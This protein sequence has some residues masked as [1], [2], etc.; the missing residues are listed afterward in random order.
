MSNY[1]KRRASPGNYSRAL[2]SSG[3]TRFNKKIWKP[4]LGFMLA[5]LLLG[6]LSS[7]FGKA[8]S[9]LGLA[10]DLNISDFANGKVIADKD[11]YKVG[12]TVTLIVAPADGY[13]PKLYINDSPL[14]LNWKNNT[15]SFVATEKIY[16][17][18]GSFEKSLD[19]SYDEDRWS[20]ANHAHGILDAY[21]ITEDSSWLMI[22]GEY[23]SVAV[24]AK[25]YLAGEDGSGGEGFAVSLGLK[26]TNNGNSK[27]YTF[28]VVKQGGIY[29]LQ[30]FNI[31]GDWTK[32]VLDAAAVTAI[33]GEGVDFKVV[34]TSAN[35]LT[36]FVNGVVCDTYEMAD[37][38]E[39][40][41]VSSVNIGLYGNPNAQI[42]IPYSLG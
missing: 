35:M 20:V 42:A 16:K 28:R 22:N 6:F 18:T 8:P 41:K 23:E 15:Y 12:D 34:R 3:R 25:N 17:I 14:L 7:M 9:K 38:T 13:S 33:S 2:R 32:H 19:M 29:Y 4:I 39:E 30:R 5:V 31:S 37:V 36:V 10:V 24:K 26:L 40:F 1:K 21:Y 27:T 11:S